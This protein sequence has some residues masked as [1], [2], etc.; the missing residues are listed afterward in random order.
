MPQVCQ[1]EILKCFLICKVLFHTEYKLLEFITP[2]GSMVENKMIF[3][4]SLGHGWYIAATKTWTVLSLSDPKTK[5]NVTCPPMTYL[6]GAPL[7][8]NGRCWMGHSFR[9]LS[10]CMFLRTRRLKNF[11]HIFIPEVC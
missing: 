8:K 11:H 3:Q 1:R 4:N 10:I 9:R 5:G 2:R 7:D 6:L